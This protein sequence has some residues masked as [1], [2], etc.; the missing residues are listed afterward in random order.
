N[1]LN[2]YFWRTYDQQEIDLVE[3]KNGQLFAFEIKWNKERKFPPKIWQETY[4]NSQ[5]QSIN[6]DNFLEFI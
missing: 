1:S 6:K 4:P 2:N 3:E 5:W